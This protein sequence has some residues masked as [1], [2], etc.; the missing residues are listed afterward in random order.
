V[1]KSNIYAVVERKNLDEQHLGNIL[2]ASVSR[3]FTPLQ[4]ALSVAVRDKSIIDLLYKYGVTCSYDEYRLFK[5]SAAKSA[6]EARKG[7]VFKSKDG[8]VQVVADNFDANIS[9]QNGLLS[10]HSLAVNSKCFDG[11]L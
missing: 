4:I 10:T 1:H 2:T 7:G 9:S 8:L 11:C 5:T 6:C 3:G